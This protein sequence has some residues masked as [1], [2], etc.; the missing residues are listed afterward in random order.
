[1]EKKTSDLF[2]QASSFA[3]DFF[4]TLATVPAVLATGYKL[5]GA[6]KFTTEYVRLLKSPTVLA[7][8]TTM[9]LIGAM[10]ERTAQRFGRFHRDDERAELDALREHVRE[11]GL[12]VYSD[13]E[14]IGLKKY[15]DGRMHAIRVTKAEN[16]TVQVEPIASE[17]SS[18]AA[19]SSPE[20][21][22]AE[23]IAMRAQ[24]NQT[25]QILLHVAQEVEKGHLGNSTLQLDESS[26]P[27]THVARLEA[28]KAMQQLA[29]VAPSLTH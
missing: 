11:E 12:T 18:S 2:V 13:A 14:G 9:G 28:E 16:G 26:A 25:G 3:M 5:F 6:K 20:Q 21:L 10:L 29:A 17:F 8:A 7:T 23:N 1:M 22:Q 27:P 24:L 15:V 4:T 19:M